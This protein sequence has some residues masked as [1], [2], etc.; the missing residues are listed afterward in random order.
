M[1]NRAHHGMTGLI[2]LRVQAS[3]T[4]WTIEVDD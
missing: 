4:P 2:N 1:R 3:P